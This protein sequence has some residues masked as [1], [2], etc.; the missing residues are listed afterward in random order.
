LGKAYTYLSMIY[1]LF[2]FAFV[3]A[4]NPCETATCLV[5]KTRPGCD[6][7]TYDCLSTNS[8]T[9]KDLNLSPTTTCSMCQAGSCT[10]CYNQTGCSWFSS[11]VPGIPGTCAVNSSTP[12]GYNLVATCPTCNG[13]TACGTCTANQNST[14]CGWWT[15]PGGL[16]GKCREASPAF[17]YTQTP[18]AFCGL[19]VNPCAGLNTCSQCLNATS[20]VNNATNICNWFTSKSTALYN[21]KC[22]QNLAGVLNS[23][24]YTALTGT[25]PICAPSTC[26]DCAADT[27]NSA[28]GGCQ[29]LAVNLGAGYAFGQCVT[30][31]VTVTGK[32]VV[33]T[34]PNACSIYS[35]TSCA[36][37]TGCAWFTGS[38]IGID[39]TCALA[40]STTEHLSQTAVTVVG[41][42]PNCAADR[43]FE[44]NNLNGCGWYAD[45]VG[46]FIYA[47]GCYATPGPSGRTLIQNTNSKCA[48]A[49]GASALAVPTGLLL[50]GSLLAL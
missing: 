19:G 5:C 39:D 4:D 46:S 44:C 9:V 50:I 6:W 30:K 33:P 21:S 45:T 1:L 37:T 8:S 18:A 38:K 15:L 10:D 48:G 41:S 26:T 12:T 3:G 31:G 49:S 43:C 47:Q 25:C 14:G 32:A 11:V 13:N 22:D 34:C 16:S 36:S 35:C 20:P 27:T 17:D 28:N 23:A 24:F 29:W 7:Y 42:C 40:S 2:I